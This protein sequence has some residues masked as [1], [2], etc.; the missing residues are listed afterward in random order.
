[1]QTGVCWVFLE[2]SLESTITALTFISHFTITTCVSGGKT[3]KQNHAQIAFKILRLL[4]ADTVSALPVWKTPATALDEKLAAIQS[5]MRDCQSRD[6]HSKCRPVAYAP[7]RLVAVGHDGSPIKLVGRDSTTEATKYVA[8][9]YCWGKSLQ[10]CTTKSTLSKFT[11]EIPSELIP[12]TWIDAIQIAR[13]LRIPHVWIDALCIVHDD[14]AEWQREV[15]QMSKI[16]QGSLLTIAAVQSADSCQGCFP[17]SDN[18]GFQ[19][20]ELCFRTRPDSLG[21]RSSIVRVYREDIRNRAGGNTA[22]SNRGWTLQE[23]LLSP[24]LVL[25]MQPEVHWQCR[26]GYQTESGLSFEL[27]ELLQANNKLLPHYDGLQTS[28]RWHRRA[29]RRIIEGYSLREFS[30]SEDRIPAIAGITEYFSSVLDDAPIL[31][32]WRKSFA[33]DLAWLR[34]GGPPQMADITGLPSWT[35][36]TGQGCVLYTIG[37]RYA[38][39]EDNGVVESLRLLDWDVQWQGAPFVSPVDSALVRVEAPVREIRIVPFEEGNRHIPPYFQVFE[40]NLQP[41]A[42]R[43]IPWRCAGRFDDGD[44][45]TA[46]TYLCLLLYSEPRNSESGDVREVFLILGPVEMEKGTEMRYKRVGVARIWGESPTFD[47]ANTMSIVLV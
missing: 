26:A 11:E 2:A 4:G 37:D 7:L 27:A 24:R 5:W 23:Q 41:T 1:M 28:D 30:Y 22:I 19:E 17:S 39:H 34:G 31:G 46:A 33:M 12:K 16:Y 20:G 43:M 32:L 3:V 25:C 13:A 35:W 14:E 42:Q 45:T 9:S 18:D 38:D 36:F 15:T 21:G 40:E 44:A 10:L 6:G 8:L 47:S 29:W